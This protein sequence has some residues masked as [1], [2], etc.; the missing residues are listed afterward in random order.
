[1]MTETLANIHLNRQQSRRDRSNSTSNGSPKIST[2]NGN[3]KINSNCGMFQMRHDPV[4]RTGSFVIGQKLRESKWFTH[5][6]M[7]IFCAVVESGFIIEQKQEDVTR[8]GVAIWA[9]SY[10]KSWPG[11]RA[12]S[13][14]VLPNL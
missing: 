5:A 11:Q 7:N 10:G 9:P 4:K 6:E 13:R 2:S 12:K 8:Y 3:L 1:M 14:V